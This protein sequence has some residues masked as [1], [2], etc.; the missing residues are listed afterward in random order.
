MPSRDVLGLQLH[1]QTRDNNLQPRPCNLDARLHLVT[2]V[3]TVHYNRLNHGKLH[4]HHTNKLDSINWK[5]ELAL[6]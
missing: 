2:N 1:L 6:L 3:I 4:S 5:G